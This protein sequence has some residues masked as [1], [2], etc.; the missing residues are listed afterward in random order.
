MRL[1]PMEPGAWS[2]EL[3]EGDQ[4][5]T[6]RVIVP[7]GFLDQLALVD[8]D[9]ERVARETLGFLLD[10]LPST[11]LPAEISVYDVAEEHPDFTDELLTRLA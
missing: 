5:T 10:R 8:G 7:D 4:R 9:P 2:A 6:H 3:D 11:A 1:L